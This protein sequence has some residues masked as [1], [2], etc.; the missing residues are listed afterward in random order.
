MSS[1]YCEPNGR[2]T[3]Q[4]HNRRSGEET[5]HH[6][7]RRSVLVARG[8][9]LNNT[10]YHATST[11][12]TS[13]LQLAAFAFVQH[14]DCDDSGAEIRPQISIH[15][16]PRHKQHGFCVR[17]HFVGICGVFGTSEAG[18]D[19]EGVQTT[20]THTYICVCV[21]I[22]IFFFPHTHRWLMCIIIYVMLYLLT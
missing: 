20:H 7:I 6:S 9:L 2:A 11:K 22:Y 14:I 15:A 10:Q 4:K 12:S 8:M 21:Y 5:S 19:L 18:V 17:H 13:L 3:C 16:Y 1:Q